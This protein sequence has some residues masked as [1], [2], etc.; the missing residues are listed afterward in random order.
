[1]NDFAALQAEM[2][3]WRRALHAQP[4]FGFEE[5]ETA[6]FVASKLRA[7]GL[8]EVIEGVGGTGVVG[9]LSRGAGNRA[10][11]LR[12]DMDALRIAEQGACVWRSERPGLMHACGH[13]GHTAM[14]L[15]A[16]KRLSQQGGFDGVVRFVFQPAEEWGRGARAMLDDALR[17]RFP[18]D[19][20]YGLHN[21][22]GLATGAFRT[23]AGALMAAEDNFEIELKGIGGHSSRP[24]AI[25]ETMLAAC[26]LVVNLQTIV[27][28]RLDPADT[29]VLSVTELKTDGA[30][31]V[32]PGNA[33]ILGDV[34]HFD[35]AIS[36]RV[37]QEM[38]RLAEGAALAHGLHATVKYTHEFVPLINDPGLSEEMLAAARDALG[39]E[40]VAFAEAPI[41]A[42]ED[43]A[44]FLAE[45]PGAFAFLGNGLESAPLHN[46]A[47]DFNDAILIEGVKF[48]EAL[49][50]RRLSEKGG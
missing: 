50:R 35:P 13:D 45:V 10:I 31:N 7:F 49:T 8:D 6:A 37:E 21:M 11:A 36:A 9:S 5:R 39:S 16:A 26:A 23:R 44:A 41:T 38:R 12:A 25:C 4:E 1:M 2:T 3:D 30:R 34:R 32:L 18:F 29:A 46:P 42:S 27:S 43:F 17:K 19:E 28:R 14:L 15:G 47:Y 22:P 20:I 33:R 40:R 48:Y 24:H